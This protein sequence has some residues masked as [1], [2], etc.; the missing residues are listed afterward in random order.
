MIPGSY[1]SAAAT[2]SEADLNDPLPFFSPV[3]VAIPLVRI[4]TWHVQEKR[5][6]FSPLYD[7]TLHEDS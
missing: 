1:W 2:E 6:T 7:Y 3:Y 5:C 4:D